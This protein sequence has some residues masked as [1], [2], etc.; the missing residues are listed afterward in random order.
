MASNECC[1]WYQNYLRRSMGTTKSVKN[2]TR[3]N[4]FSAMSHVDH[5]Y[6]T[7]N[8][9]EPQQFPTCK[10]GRSIR[11]GKLALRHNF[12]QPQLL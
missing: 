3:S 9:R 8:G 7:T 5:S 2:T 11:A 10:M 12:Q 6:P 4:R 1:E